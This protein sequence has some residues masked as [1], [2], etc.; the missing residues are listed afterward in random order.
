MTDAVLMR[1]GKTASSAP[2]IMENDRC[3]ADEKVIEHKRSTKNK[4]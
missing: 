1:E 4:M 3:G 2:K